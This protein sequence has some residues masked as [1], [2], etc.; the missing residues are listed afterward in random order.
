M[1]RIFKVQRTMTAEVVVSDEHIAQGAGE[2]WDPIQVA[3][4]LACSL[5]DSDWDCVDTDVWEET[6]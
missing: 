3:E 4:E 6:A 2:G 1:S 5:E